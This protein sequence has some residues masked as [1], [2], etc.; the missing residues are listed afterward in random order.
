MAHKEKTSF[1]IKWIKFTVIYF[2]ITLIVWACYFLHN[3][4]I[5][6]KLVQL[7]N[8]GTYIPVIDELMILTTDFSIIVIS[9]IFVFWEIGFQISQI[10]PSLKGILANIFKMLGIA[11]AIICLSMVYWMNYEHNDIFIFLGLAM[12]LGFWLMGSTYIDYGDETLKRINKVF[13]LSFISLIL[14]DISVHYV[15]HFIFRPRPLSR[16]NVSWNYTLRIFPDESVMSG[17]SYVSGHASALFALLTPVFWNCR[18]KTG[19]ICALGWAS[20]H[21]YSRVY[22]A[23]HFF[24]CTIMGSIMGFAI[25]TACVLAFKTS[26]DQGNEVYQ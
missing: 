9:S 10:K 7:I 5:D 12:F 4:E 11:S 22:V 3:D 25:A 21:A 15:K 2:L 17:S 13:W 18:R 6:R 1:L 20:L 26:L 19:K 24:Y 14:A 16:L 23:A 8:P